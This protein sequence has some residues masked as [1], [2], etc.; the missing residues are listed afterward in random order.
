LAS[1]GN[2]GWYPHSSAI[3]FHDPGFGSITLAQSSFAR[4]ACVKYGAFNYYTLGKAPTSVIITIPGV[5]ANSPVTLL[6]NGQIVDITAS[7]N[8]TAHFYDFQ[9]GTYQAIDNATGSSWKIVISG[10]SV[11]VTANSPNPGVSRP[12]IGQIFPLGTYYGARPTMPNVYEQSITAPGITPFT[13]PATVTSLKLRVWAAD[14]GGGGSLGGSTSG[15]SGGGGGGYAEGVVAVTPG[16]VINFNIGAAGVGGAT[17]A[18]NGTNGGNT[19]V[20]GTGIAVSCNGGNPGVYAPSTAAVNG[21]TGGSASGLTF[22]KSGQSGGPGF[23]YGTGEA[24]SGLPAPAY[25][26][27]A[28]N[29]GGAN[30]IG[31][32]SGQ[33][34]QAFIEWVQ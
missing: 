18:N 3:T 1:I 12:T 16:Q 27:I 14:G 29:G 33:A 17:G 9:D 5:T 13:V 28:T 4:S 8:T 19:T 10:T 21:G 7:S 11:T 22:T 34:G 31:G 20:T 6:R 23:F 32:G 2:I 24:A 30:G 15:G 25:G 26:R